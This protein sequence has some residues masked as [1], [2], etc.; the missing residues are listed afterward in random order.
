[1]NYTYRPWSPF[2]IT[3]NEMVYPSAW[4]SLPA[5]LQDCCLQG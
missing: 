2:K 3:G 5:N 4:N 1:M